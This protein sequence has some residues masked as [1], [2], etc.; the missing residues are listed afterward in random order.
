MGFCQPCHVAKE[1]ERLRVRVGMSQGEEGSQLLLKAKNN[2]DTLA[3]V[4][5]CA[6]VCDRGRQNN[7]HV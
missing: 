7:S 1:W 5:V 3:S 2:P 6:R 4:C